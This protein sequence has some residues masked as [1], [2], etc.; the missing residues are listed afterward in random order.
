MKYPNTIK[1]DRRLS[2]VALIVLMPLLVL[3]QN[4]GIQT[5]SPDSTLSIANKV[6]I[7]GAQGD[8]LFTDDEASIIFP[9]TT[10]PNSPMMYMFKSGGSNDDRMGHCTLAIASRLGPPV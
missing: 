8:I 4:V 9:A 5:I 7:G 6:E 2:C 1:E 10:L 3:A